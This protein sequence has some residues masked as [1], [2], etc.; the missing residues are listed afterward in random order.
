MAYEFQDQRMIQG[1]E[2]I[3]R[4]I[5]DFQ[6]PIFILLKEIHPDI[7]CRNDWLINYL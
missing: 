7:K 4:V 6:N 5:D 3:D 1:D 2:S